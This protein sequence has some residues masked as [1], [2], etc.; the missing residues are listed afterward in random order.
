[1]LLAGDIGGTKTTLAVFTGDDGLKSPVLERTFPS[2]DYLR[3]EDILEEFL[4]ELGD[5]PAYA[6]LGV[7]GP[8]VEGRARV[9]NLTWVIDAAH[10]KAQFAFSAVHLLNDLQA[11]A[12]GVTILDADDL[13]ILHTGKP[14]STGTIAII[15]PGTGLG[16]AF[17][18]WNG[19]RYEA[20]PS[21]GGHTN[22]GPLDELQLDMLRYLMRRFGHVSYERVC[23]GSGLP[24]I[25]AFLK[26]G[27]YGQEPE[28]LAERLA[29]TNDP[30]PVIVTA[31]L[32]EEMPCDLCRRTL[33]IFVSILGSEAANLALKVMATGGLYIGGGI[34]PRI[35]SLLKTER[36][37]RPFFNKGRLSSVL[38][39][40]PVYVI[41]N[42]RVG[43]L[44]AARH[45]LQLQREQA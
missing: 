10:L 21:E 1:M 8:V 13:E 34:P 18:T 16:E 14:V 4:G 35:V 29:A 30:T 22:F 9:T 5:R 3:L 36:F 31:A 27:G 40:V 26:D 39:D 24:N 6:V 11:I 23:S 28:W 2:Q 43:L 42:P 33:E 44:G 25:Y 41:L 37:S 17:L 32:D 19:R 7:A 38:S 45:A 12:E 15:A 20:H